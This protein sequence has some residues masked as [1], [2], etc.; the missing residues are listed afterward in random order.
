[1]GIINS[2]SLF[3]WSFNLQFTRPFT[4]WCSGKFLFEEVPLVG[5]YINAYRRTL[6]CS[7]VNFLNLHVASKTLL[8]P[9]KDNPP[10][11]TWEF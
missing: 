3:Q 5:Q 11:L 4:Q 7:S 8:L 9:N 1:M 2:S 10:V 6:A